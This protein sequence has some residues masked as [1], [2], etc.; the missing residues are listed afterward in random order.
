[1]KSSPIYTIRLETFGGRQDKS[2][3]KLKIQTTNLE[4]YFISSLDIDE[5]DATF[6]I[7]L[8]PKKIV[9]IVKS[10]TTPEICLKT[11][12]SRSMLT[13]VGQFSMEMPY[14]DTLDN[15]PN[16]P[17]EE[18]KEDKKTVSELNNAN[19]KTVDFLKAVEQ[20]EY[21]RS[22]DAVKQTYQKLYIES[23]HG[24]A[25]L[26]CT[27]GKRLGVAKVAC[28]INSMPNSEPFL[29]RFKNLLVPE[30]VTD[31]IKAL[32]TKA[33]FVAFSFIK[34]YSLPV[35]EKPESHYEIAKYVTLML[36]NKLTGDTRYIFANEGVFPNID[37]VIPKED[38]AKVK[39]YANKEIFTKAIAGLKPIWKDTDSVTLTCR[40]DSISLSARNATTAEAA[41]II[42]EKLND[43]ATTQSDYAFLVTLNP[44]YL[45][46]LV[47]RFDK[48]DAILFEIGGASS[49]IVV[50]LK[51]C[52]GTVHILMPI[53]LGYTG[54]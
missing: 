3:N 28:E 47:S 43:I 33:E 13:V 39:F 24:E 37:A 6:D 20:I 15:Y 49:P 46:E 45:S 25:R 41:I 32:K 54:K 52:K 14:M 40:T 10:M 7:M 18:K 5:D 8:D 2:K 36:G 1:M 19:I 44:R 30:C 21:A 42:T 23:E 31:S 9:D 48:K 29:K 35:T 34:R 12:S 51:D 11:Q 17:F 26:A 16:L 22:G 53:R 27:D 4:V 50:S 38:A